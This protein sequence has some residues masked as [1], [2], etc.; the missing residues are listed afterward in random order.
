MIHK[1]LQLLLGFILILLL[2]SLAF[3]NVSNSIKND[4]LSQTKSTLKDKG[5]Q[6]IEVEVEGEGWGITRTII[7]K[8]SVYSETQKNKIA[9]MLD[10]IS[11]IASV[12]NQIVVISPNYYQ[13]TYVAVPPREKCS[14][15]SQK[16][17]IHKNLKAEITTEDVQ[18]PKLI[19]AKELEISQKPIKSKEVV[20]PVKA[21]DVSS[22][23]LPKVVKPIDVSTIKVITPT[24][25]T[26]EIPKVV[27][28]V[29][30]VE[31]AKEGEK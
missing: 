8:G 9:S 18:A 19:K 16:Q 6:E 23:T 3:S 10:E 26:V 1:S 5:I 25:S 28:V 30:V 11:G 21:V 15:I 4:L 24:Q 20:A 2:A 7:L 14:L 31:V 29:K 12:D 22:Q 13:E 17:V 27:D